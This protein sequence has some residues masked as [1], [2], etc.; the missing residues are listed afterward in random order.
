MRRPVIN[1]CTHH[2]DNGRDLIALALQ[3]W[4]RDVGQ[5]KNTFIWRFAICSRLAQK[6]KRVARENCVNNVGQ[7]MYLI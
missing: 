1:T 5:G 7:A 4:S 6:N 2:I 3:T